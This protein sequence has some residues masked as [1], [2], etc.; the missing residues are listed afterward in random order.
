M[1]KLKKLFGETEFSMAKIVIFAVLAGIFT[2]IM[3]LIPQL[4]NSSFGAITVTFEVWILIGISIITNAKSNLDSAIKCFVFFMISQ[5]LVYLLQVPFSDMGWELFTYYP[6]WF[7]WTVLCI[8]MGFIGY[9][10]KK[11]KWYGYI[12]LLPMLILTFMGYRTYLLYFIFSRP[13]YLL[14]TVFCAVM[15]VLYSIILFENKKLR[16]AGSAVC[17][18]VVCVIT[19]LVLLNPHCYS[20]EITSSIDGH[21]ITDE[22]E[23]A[24]EDSKYG[25]VRIE[26]IESADAYMVHADFRR[27]GR[28]KLLVTTPEGDVK[29]Y[30]LEIEYST[31]KLAEQ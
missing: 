24:L 12:I 27:G 9:Y 2:A 19:V 18:T 6:R 20:T 5:P 11:G 1:K 3:A 7:V 26:Y 10:I 8:P 23:V 31:Y 13:R 4:R 17:I 29:A 14:I 16:I 30:N 21:D 15:P 28:T 25:E 22:Y